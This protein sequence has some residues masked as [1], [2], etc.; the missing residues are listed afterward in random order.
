MSHSK[1]SWQAHAE[2]VIGFS[3]QHQS[4]PNQDA[5]HLVLGPNSGFPIILTIADGHGSD[6]AFRSHL[7]SRFAV[8]VSAELLKNCLD[9]P[10]E[11][12]SYALIYELTRQQLPMRL[13]QEWQDKVKQHLKQNPFTEEERK[14]LL[15][16]KDMQ[17]M[18]G[19][20]PLGQDPTD[21]ED[22]LR[23]Y[24]PYGTT[25]LGVA[26]TASFILYLQIGDGDILCLK[27][28]GTAY[29]PIPKD[30]RLFGNETTSLCLANAW[31]DLTF[32][33]EPYGDGAPA[34]IFLATDGYSNSFPSEVDLQNDLRLYFDWLKEDGFDSIK[35]ELPQVLTRMTK[36]GSG[37]DITVGIIRS[38]AHNTENIVTEVKPTGSAS[39]EAK[40][41][42][43]ELEVINKVNDTG[44]VNLILLALALLVF[45]L[46]VFLFIRENYE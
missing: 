44:F 43:G 9:K 45:V 40:P 28:D 36:D 25:L 20:H 26:I 33:M 29:R 15:S 8:E 38:I 18:S 32:Q 17:K 14:F 6:R 42:E 23:N 16:D 41:R 11:E 10:L 2:S 19:K 46:L 39:E 30:S 22:S 21:K 34:M 24:Y 3:H 5:Y 35:R 7:G 13:V 12:I 27:E 4:K 31:S 1:F 37:D